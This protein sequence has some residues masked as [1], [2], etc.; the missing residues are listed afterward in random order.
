MGF[1]GFDLMA[2]H[3]FGH[4]LTTG[5]LRRETEAMYQYY[6]QQQF[7]LGGLGKGGAVS[8]GEGCFRAFFF[9]ER[10]HP[11]PLPHDGSMGGM[12]YLPS[13]FIKLT[14]LWQIV[15]KYTSC[16][17]DLMGYSMECYIP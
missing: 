4:R 15:G 7:R 14:F 9:E 10:K 13:C 16:L 11:K 1:L 12:V 5:A 2:T 17:M 3:L 8:N 6:T